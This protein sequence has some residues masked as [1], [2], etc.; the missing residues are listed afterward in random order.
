MLKKLEIINSSLDITTLAPVN[1]SILSIHVE[2]EFPL[3][4]TATSLFMTNSTIQASSIY[5]EAANVSLDRSS[6]LNVSNMGLKFGPGYNSWFDM[7]GSYGGIGGA[8]LSRDNT[9]CNQLP[10]NEYIKPIGD[11]SGKLMDFRG[12]GSGGGN[13]QARGGGRI[14]LM[15]TE[16]ITINGSFLANGANVYKGRLESA[17]SGKWAY[18]CFHHFSHKHVEQCR[19]NHHHQNFDHSRNRIY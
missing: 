13:D 8:A 6:V 3:N 15:V 12:Y 16:F 18:L 4:K 2:A 7:G 14:E 17:G 9:N 19:R 5:I 10:E 1:P 11:I